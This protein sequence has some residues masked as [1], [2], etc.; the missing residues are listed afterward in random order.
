M[1]WRVIEWRSPLAFDEGT[2]LDVRS[3]MLLDTGLRATSVHRPRGPAPGI[4]AAS[5]YNAFFGQSVALPEGGW[6]LCRRPHLRQDSNAA[7]HCCL[8]PQSRHLLGTHDALRSP[9]AI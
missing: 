7:R 8:S 5:L 4:N 2:V 9:I 3:A 6:S 1:A